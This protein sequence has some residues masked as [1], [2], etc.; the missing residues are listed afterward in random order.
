MLLPKSF[1]IEIF[2]LPLSK[3]RL[4]V[5][6]DTWRLL[7][8]IGVERLHIPNDPE[9]RSR[10]ENLLGRLGSSFVREVKSWLK[11]H[12]CCQTA[13]GCI[14]ERARW[15]VFH[16]YFREIRLVPRFEGAH[17]YEVAGDVLSLSCE[18]DG[19]ASLFEDISSSVSPGGVCVNIISAPL[20]PR[21]VV[22]K[23]VPVIFGVRACEALRQD[24]RLQEQ[25][26]HAYWQTVWAE[27]FLRSLVG[28]TEPVAF[29][30]VSRGPRTDGAPENVLFIEPGRMLVGYHTVDHYWLARACTSGELLCDFRKQQ[31]TSTASGAGISAALE[32]LN[33][34]GFVDRWIGENA[35]L[36]GARGRVPIQRLVPVAGSEILSRLAPRLSDS[37]YVAAEGL[38]GNLLAA[39]NSVFFLNFPEEYHNLHSAM[40]DLVGLLVV[41]GVLWQP[42][43]LRRASLLIDENGHAAVA[44]VSM[45]DCHLDLGGSIGRIEH[46]AINEQAA[47]GDL[48]TVYT[49]SFTARLPP[50][51]NLTP[52]AEVVDLVI[53]DCRIVEIH[54]GGG[55][56]IPMN[57]FVLSLPGADP[58]GIVRHV[59]ENGARV[60]IE[61]DLAR[62]GLSSIRTAIAAGPQLV[63][64]GRPLSPDY[65]A[66][67]TEEFV[68]LRLDRSGIVQ[69]GL[70]PTR[71][72]HSVTHV[73]APR[74][75]LGITHDDRLLLIT[76]DGRNWEH[77]VGMTL[78]EL[79]R[80]LCR[81]GCR[82]ALN[83]DG[84]GSTVMYV[85]PERCDGAAII[86]GAP[87]G[88][89]NRPSDVGGR[90]RLIPAPLGVFEL[91][92]EKKH[93]TTQPKPMVS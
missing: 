60:E 76:V 71:F 11:E 31:F 46:F 35:N 57:G 67:G 27:G 38:S 3:R 61:L 52:R 14:W 63:K 39:T 26:A 6:P 53:V 62:L 81:L 18:A 56:A 92:G 13:S 83:L 32:R 64:G 58:A 77:S 80:F 22:L 51:K 78:L 12:R 44:V 19:A 21:Q 59:R 68:P 36:C 41:D 87:A 7:R 23:P 17:S 54:R 69:S 90:D 50:H 75:A 25:I 2:D 9:C 79:A 66:S 49:P 34:C 86:P 1:P 33:A 47:P 48:P 4:R 28:K 85:S 16:P 24:E 8:R 84:G 93:P 10:C 40:N 70:P 65:L 5:S 74:T 82:E 89:V 20:A 30:P 15:Q 88:I 43:L 91:S 45:A 37:P 55:T 29:L 42:P 72:P 73:R